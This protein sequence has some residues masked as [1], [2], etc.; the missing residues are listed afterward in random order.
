MSPNFT[1]RIRYRPG[2]DRH[3]G[4][5]GDLA[6]GD[7]RLSGPPPLDAPGD[8]RG[9]CAGTRG[10]DMT[11]APGA[12][13]PIGEIT[14]QTIAM[15]ADSNANGD[16]FGGWL[17]AQMDLGA[18]VMARRRARGR[19]ATVAVDAMQFLRPVKIGDVVS[20]H[21]EMAHEGRTSMRIGI[22]V[23]AQR[24]PRASMSR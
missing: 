3:L 16:I 24:Q 12:D 8:G 14:L 6:Q 1:C 7:Q 2:T 19:V 20:I 23:W 13:E 15:P 11:G 18:S 4:Q 9:L 17:M 21:A 22:E 5:P 10:T